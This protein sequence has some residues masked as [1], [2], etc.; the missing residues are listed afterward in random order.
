M[1]T[2]GASILNRSTTTSALDCD[3]RGGPCDE[4]VRPEEESVN[5]RI[6]LP[7]MATECVVYGAVSSFILLFYFNAQ[8]EAT[9]KRSEHQLC[10]CGIEPIFFIPP[11]LSSSGW[12][13]FPSLMSKGKPAAVPCPSQ[14]HRHIA[15]AW[16]LRFFPHR[17]CLM[18]D[19]DS[20]PQK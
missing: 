6:L 20:L 13:P 7:L 4:R 1:L 17:L 10:R 5:H 2:R 16:A 18:D 8:A 3:E 12:R 14:Q 9:H 19:R 11:P 15:R